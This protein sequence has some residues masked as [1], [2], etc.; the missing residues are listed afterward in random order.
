MAV[1]AAYAPRRTVDDDS[2]TRNTLERLL[3]QDNR[4]RPSLRHFEGWLSN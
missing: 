2:H 1:T 3:G 4:L